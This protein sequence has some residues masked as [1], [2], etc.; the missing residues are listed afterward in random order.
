MTIPKQWLLLAWL[1]FWLSL[2]A[3]SPHFWS[4]LAERGPDCISGHG[5]IERHDFTTAN[6]SVVI[7][8]GTQIG[9]T[10]ESAIRVMHMHVPSLVSCIAFC[11]IF[12]IAGFAPILHEL[13]L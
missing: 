8:N 5:W 10:N 3:I 13:G 4:Y 12:V 7:V 11:V 6:T 9:A 1:L 2:A